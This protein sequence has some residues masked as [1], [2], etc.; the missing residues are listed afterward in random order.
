MTNL[1]FILENR[2]QIGVEG[3]S[4]CKLCYLIKNSNICTNDYYC[5]DCVKCRFEK[6][7]NCYEFLNEEYKEHSFLTKFERDL[8]KAVTNDLEFEEQDI[9]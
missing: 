4:I 8:L 6:M 3:Y 7:I 1:E 5:K 9:C 2:E